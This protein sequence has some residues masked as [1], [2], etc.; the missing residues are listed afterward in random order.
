MAY[1]TIPTDRNDQLR[2]FGS[3]FANN[4][5]YGFTAASRHPADP[6][7]QLYSTTI[8][9][10]KKSD[11]SYKSIKVTNYVLDN[12]WDEIVRDY[13]L[14]INVNVYDWT[15]YKT[16]VDDGGT[17]DPNMEEWAYL[18]SCIANRHAKLQKWR[19]PYT[20]RLVFEDGVVQ[21]FNVPATEDY[22]DTIGNRAYTDYSAYLWGYDSSEPEWAYYAVFPPEL[23]VDVEIHTDEYDGYPIY[24]DYSHIAYIDLA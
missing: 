14:N 12:Y 5:G 11:F 24:I 16:W 7:N 8:D 4:G 9:L 13:Y 10:I 2:L 1:L 18:Y 23:F 21:E 15:Y 6:L 22:Y 3:G 20:A 17:G 19:Y